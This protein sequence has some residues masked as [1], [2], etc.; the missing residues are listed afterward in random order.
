MDRYVAGT[1]PI[2]AGRRGFDAGVGNDPDAGPYGGAWSG[3]I[4]MLI[5]P[6]GGRP[7]R[8]H[9]FPQCDIAEAVETGMTAAGGKNLD[10]FGLTSLDSA[11]SKAC[12]MSSTCTSRR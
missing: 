6:P 2:L 4:F 8:R 3:P 7:P 9:Y 1:G 10:V 11:W 12:S 5:P